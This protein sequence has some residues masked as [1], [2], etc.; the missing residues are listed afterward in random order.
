MP[1]HEA[2][3]LDQAGRAQRGFADEQ[4]RAKADAARELVGLVLQDGTK[5]DRRAADRDTRAGL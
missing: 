5:R 3:G 2:T 1:A 4:A